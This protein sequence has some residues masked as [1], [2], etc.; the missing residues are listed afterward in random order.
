SRDRRPTPA[1]T[2]GDAMLTPWRRTRQDRCSRLAL[3]APSTFSFGLN[4]VRASSKPYVVQETWRCVGEPPE[5]DGA[6]NPNTANTTQIRFTARIQQWSRTDVASERRTPLLYSGAV[7]GEPK[8][9][10]RDLHHEV[11]ATG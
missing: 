9:Q 3:S 4:P 8:T 2:T 11:V 10:W 1:A 5:H 7:S 6:S